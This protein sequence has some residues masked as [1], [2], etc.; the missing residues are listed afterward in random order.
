MTGFRSWAER[1]NVNL[2]LEA[3]EH[4]EMTADLAKVETHL[5]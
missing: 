5:L 3:P 1:I 2:C 4:Y